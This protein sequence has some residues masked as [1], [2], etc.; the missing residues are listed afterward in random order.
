MSI[1]DSKMQM[2]KKKFFVK[3]LIIQFTAFLLQRPEDNKLR[4]I[5]RL[6]KVSLLNTDYYKVICLV[7]S[8]DAPSL[9]YHF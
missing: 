5:K 2:A 7:A 6:L 4:E 9:A 1:N 8:L 3:L